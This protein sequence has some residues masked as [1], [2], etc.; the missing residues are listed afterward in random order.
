MAKIILYERKML[1]EFGKDYVKILI[2]LLKKERKV[3][4][5]ALIN[6]ID[7]RLVETA[8][9]IQYQLLSNDYLT[10][11]DQGRRPGSYPN[12]RAIADWVRI[13][14]ISKDAI[15]PIARSIFKFG[16]EPTNVLSKTIQEIE[17]SPALRKKYEDELVDNL[18]K[19][20]AADIIKLGQ[21]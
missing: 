13:K 11:V 18:E 7:Y 5:G 4:S 16:I 17:T 6:S 19:L 12:M 20:L 2:R 8:K 14:G 21:K 3:A 15:F 1:N 9:L 10:Y